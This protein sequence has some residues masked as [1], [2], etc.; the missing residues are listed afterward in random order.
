[1]LTAHGRGGPYLFVMAVTIISVKT[2]RKVGVY[3]LVVLALIMGA[4]STPVGIQRVGTREAHYLLTAN[5]LSSGTPSTYSLQVL[6]RQD[7]GEQ[8]ENDPEGALATL[9]A[10]L[11]SALAQDSL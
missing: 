8:F 11:Q 9:H 7:L 1:M 5:V 3:A 2:I 10:R 6:A 4:C